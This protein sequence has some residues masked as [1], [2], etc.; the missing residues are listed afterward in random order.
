MNT[1]SR[2]TRL[3]GQAASVR[4][5]NLAAY[6]A[7]EIREWLPPPRGMP[8]G[9]A[10]DAAAFVTLRLPRALGTIRTSLIDGREFY[11]KRRR[12]HQ[13][14]KTVELSIIAEEDVEILEQ[15]GSAGALTS[16]M[17]RVLEDACA[18]DASFDGGRLALLFPLSL[19]AL[20]N[21]LKALWTCGAFLPLAGTSRTYRD[22][23]EDLRAVLA[24][25]EYLSGTPLEELRRRML[26]PTARWRTWCRGY[27]LSYRRFVRGQRDPVAVAAD[28]D[29][30]APMVR[31]WF[32]LIRE[33]DPEVSSPHRMGE[34]ANPGDPYD[35]DLHLCLIHRYGYPPPAALS[36]LSRLEQISER[37]G[38]P[39]GD[40]SIIYFAVGADQPPA[41]AL[42]DMRLMPVVLDYLHPGDHEFLDVQSPAALRIR[43]LRRMAIEAYEQGASLSH[44]DLA[45][46]LGLSTDAVGRIIAANEDLKS[47]TRR[48]VAGMEPNLAGIE[49]IIRRFCRG[50]DP[51]SIVE[52]T[53]ANPAR[54][55]QYV[56]CFCRLSELVDSGLSNEELAARL[57]VTPRVIERCI[58]L[59]R[60]LGSRSER[61]SPGRNV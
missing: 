34:A 7:G 50:E 20:K 17:A 24:V 26:F 33:L 40:G 15:M 31:G 42:D 52:D 4:R 16:R 56:E 27:A 38:H 13:P 51:S 3:R 8:S 35:G 18:A 12:S 45:Y 14:Q 61:A 37:L 30:P 22:F 55:E 48:R 60:E 1:E 32:E 41:R 47:Y 29:L 53:G 54:V 10:R 44:Y 23:W 39:R 58:D 9:V 28:L 25:G 49:E 36:M 2:G 19:R 43:R 59:C 57:Q 21:R 11:A 6:L 5:K 46:L